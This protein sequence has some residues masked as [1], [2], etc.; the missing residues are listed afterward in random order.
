MGRNLPG[1]ETIICQTINYFYALNRSSD[2]F[3]TCDCHNEQFTDMFAVKVTGFRVLSQ[4]PR[5]H[6]VCSAMRFGADC[7]VPLFL[8][9]PP[10]QFLLL[11][12][13]QGLAG[14]GHAS[15]TSM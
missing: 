14:R 1:N 6:R 2:A 3:G 13:A 5:S 7:R 8:P 4:H 9:K 12:R 10:F 15:G 11:T